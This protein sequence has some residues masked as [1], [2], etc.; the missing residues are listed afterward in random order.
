MD[1]W[2]WVYETIERLDKSGEHRLA[3]IMDELAAAVAENDY[4]K[5]DSLYVEGLAL[6]RAS[7]QPWIEI[8]VRHWHLQSRL[9]SRM[10]IADWLDEAADLMQFAQQPGHRE[11]P[12]SFCVS[13]N[14]LHA[15]G[16]LDGLGYAEARI[17]AAEE[18]L[19]QITPAWPCYE[20]I[21]VEGAK[22]RRDAGQL[23]EALA[24]VD[25][26]LTAMQGAKVDA[27]YE[28]RCERARVLL[29][30]EQYQA[31]LDALAPLPEEDFL[32]RGNLDPDLLK[33]LILCE[34]GRHEDALELRPDFEDIE[35]LPALYLDWARCTVALARCGVQPNDWTLESELAALQQRL[36]ANGVIR[37]S[38]QIAHWRAEL[39][40]RRIRPETAAQCCAQIEALIPRLRQPVGAP[41]AL[42]TLQEEVDEL[43][44]DLG[45]AH[46]ALP[47]SPGQVI[48]DLARD[49]ELDLPVLEAACQKWPDHEGLILATASTL[50]ALNRNGEA[51]ASLDVFIETHEAAAEAAVSAF[52]LRIRLHGL[53]AAIEAGEAWLHRG[54]DAVEQ[55]AMR[56]MLAEAL[57][58]RGDLPRA[59]DHLQAILDQDPPP[60]PAD[61]LT[62]MVGT[63]LERW[64]AVRAAGARLGLPLEPGDTMPDPDLFAAPCSVLKLDEQG[65]PTVRAAVRIG[66][67]TARIIEM[68][69]LED[70]LNYGDEVIFDPMSDLDDDGELAESG[71][72]LRHVA[73]L[74][75]PY[76]WLIYIE[77]AG[78]PGEGALQLLTER[79]TACGVM[80]DP[81]GPQYA[82]RQ[83]DVA[84]DETHRWFTFQGALSSAVDQDT[85]EACIHAVTVGWPDQPQWQID[86]RP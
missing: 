28:L 9:F 36:T 67:A 3:Q 27:P 22:A 7:Q 68:G 15:Y 72:V 40:Q 83:P 45:P 44:G 85:V 31:A 73:D 57:E 71:P 41:E 65:L 21:A 42:L 25:E 16:S 19:S 8:F 53:E 32:T 12:H 86:P 77:G 47:D 82:A 59:M 78:D 4:S 76:P 64:A 24:Y 10:E 35:G 50:Q 29:A 80:M 18:A 11:C 79:L 70:P 74:K 58:A 14:L 33:A 69:P 30:L 23:E 84:E 63:Q 26:H 20:C 54:A 46:L 52:E 6:A 43:L 62:L 75:R 17:T 38:I 5:V 1:I 37:I 81:Q 34:M 56:G 55:V 51:L 60:G 61:V 48:Q 49:P 66:P 13:Q 39:A 2:A